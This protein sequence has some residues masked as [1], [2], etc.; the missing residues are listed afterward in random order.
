MTMLALT[1]LLL[2]LLTASGAPAPN[3][4]VDARWLADHRGDRDL[5]LLHVGRSRAAYDSAHVAGARYVDW[6]Q[7]TVTRAGI[8]VELPEPDSLAELLGALGVGDQSRIVIYGDVLPAARLWFTLDWAGHGD[9]AAVLDG[10]LPAWTALGKPVT[11]VAPPAPTRA[12]FTV[13]PDPGRV[14]DADWI[15]SRLEQ[16]GTVL[17]DARNA[18]E[19]RGDK[20]EDG[21]AR[22]GHIPGAKNLDWSETLVDGRYRSLDQVKQ[23]FARAGVTETG[24]VVAYCRTGTRAAVLYL[25]ARALGLET[26]MYDG[27]MVD[28][29][30]RAEL[31]IVTGQP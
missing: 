3:P 31:P 26:R 18:E 19:F 6:S 1:P 17:L 8:A 5:V 2:A 10:G 12:R 21:V 11:T 15:R 9:R 13:R 27:S 22:A 20:L 29:A 4:I 7:Y 16:A 23:L 30:R 25:L 28:W 24:E 14:V